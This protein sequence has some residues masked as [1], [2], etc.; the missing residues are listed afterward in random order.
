MHWNI[1]LFQFENTSVT[2][3]VDVGWDGCAVK[4]YGGVDV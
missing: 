4:A 3:S 1:M 2:Y